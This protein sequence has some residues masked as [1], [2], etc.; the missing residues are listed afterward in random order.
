MDD[1]FGPQVVYS[2]DPAGE[3]NL[4]PSAGLQFFGLVEIDGE[5]EAMTVTLKDI[6]DTA[7]YSV[8]LEPKRT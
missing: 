3:V 1:T 7:L 2:K 4:P 6:A 5:S 8:V